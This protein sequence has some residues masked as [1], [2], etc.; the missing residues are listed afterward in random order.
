MLGK[1]ILVQWATRVGYVEFWCDQCIVVFDF[2]KS[3]SGPYIVAWMGIY[4]QTWEGSLCMSDWPHHIKREIMWISLQKK[5]LEWLYLHFFCQ[6]WGDFLSQVQPTSIGLSLSEWG[7]L[8]F[9][10]RDVVQFSKNYLTGYV[11]V[12]LVRRFS[13]PIANPQALVYHWVSERAIAFFNLF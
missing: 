10:K 2:R 3:V 4:F 13:F 5:L 9:K 1:N 11:Y 6:T 7:L 12:I 8:L